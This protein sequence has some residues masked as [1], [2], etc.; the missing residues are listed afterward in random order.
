MRGCRQYLRGLEVVMAVIIILHAVWPQLNAALHAPA[1]R[2]TCQGSSRWPQ[3]LP[4][5]LVY[6]TNQP[7]VG[8]SFVSTAI[9]YHA[10][11]L[12]D[13]D[14]CF[15]K[16]RQPHPAICS[17]RSRHHLQWVSCLGLPRIG[18]LKSLFLGTVLALVLCYFRHG[19]DL[20][21]LRVKIS[22]KKGGCWY[23][24]QSSHVPPLN[25]A[26]SSPDRKLSHNVIPIN[27]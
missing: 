16:A 27:D 3:D 14:P 15:S 7:H 11:K 9:E 1:D 10:G 13:A 2:N 20:S 8:A 6:E 22:G 25:Q 12:L 4:A 24:L 21:M 19:R 17:S 18:T 23:V 26:K 5:T